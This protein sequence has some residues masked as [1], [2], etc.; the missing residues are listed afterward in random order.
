MSNTQEQVE[1]RPEAGQNKG[2]TLIEL[3]IVIAILG[4]LSVVVV[5]SVGGT[6]TSAKQKACVADKASMLNCRRGV[7]R[8]ERQ[9]PD[10]HDRTDG[11]ASSSR[12]PR[13]LTR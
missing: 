7:Q 2:F 6:T 4:I 8:I 1:T 5:L 11:R 3:L 12:P 9:I 10:R 13:R